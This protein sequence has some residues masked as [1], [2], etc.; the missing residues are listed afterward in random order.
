MIGSSDYIAGQCGTIS[1]MFRCVFGGYLYYTLATT[2]LADDRVLQGFDVARELCARCHVIGEYNRLGGIGNA[3][4]FQW[5][6]K[7]DD[8]RERFGSFYARRP[9]P[10]LFAWPATTSGP[11]PIL[12]IHRLR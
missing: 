12:T 3:P 11:K 10:C 1:T 5:M 4:S 8:W 9:Y 2:A 7:A 6:V